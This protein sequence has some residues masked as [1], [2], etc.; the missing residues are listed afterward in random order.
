MN[1]NELYEFFTKTSH[2]TLTLGYITYIKNNGMPYSVKVKNKAN[3]IIAKWIIPFSDCIKA[4]NIY[5]LSI[6]QINLEDIISI[7]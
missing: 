5:R 3:P 1:Q 2:S 6:F 7:E 4:I